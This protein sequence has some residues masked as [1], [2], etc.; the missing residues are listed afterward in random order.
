MGLLRPGGY[1]YWKGHGYVHTV[2]NFA[3]KDRWR[4][5]SRIEWIEEGLADFARTGWKSLGITSI[6]FP[7]LGTGCGGLD[8][9]AAHAFSGYLADADGNIGGL[10]T[11]KIAKAAK[12]TGLASA[13]VTIQPAGSSKKTTVRQR[14][15]VSASGAA[16]EDYL[17][18]AYRRGVVNLD[19]ERYRLNNFYGML[20]VFAVTEQAR[21]RALPEETRLALD[22]WYFS[23]YCLVCCS[24][25]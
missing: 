11:V 17:A 4:D 12:R 18:S 7:L 25:R 23:E 22:A 6:A 10:V 1:S 21:Y 14:I 20:D 9:D 19:G 16:A 3:T 8:P 5:P 24:D 15:A 2:L 13:T